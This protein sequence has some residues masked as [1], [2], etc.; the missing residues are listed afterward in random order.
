MLDGQNRLNASYLAPKMM[1]FIR[2][3]QGN[4][5]VDDATVQHLGEQMG[6]EF[7]VGYLIRK[8]FA[9]N[10]KAHW[11]KIQEYIFRLIERQIEQDRK[12][13]LL[14]TIRHIFPIYRPIVLFYCIM[15]LSEQKMIKKELFNQNSVQD[16]EIE[17]NKQWIDALCSLDLDDFPEAVKDLTTETGRLRGFLVGTALPRLLNNEYFE[18][19]EHIL[20]FTLSFVQEESSIVFWKEYFSLKRAYWNMLPQEPVSKDQR[21][22]VFYIALQKTLYDIFTEYQD[23][24]KYSERFRDLQSRLELQI[25]THGS[26]ASYIDTP[27][28]QILRQFRERSLLETEDN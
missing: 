19:S 25:R 7:Y 22:K 12:P 13:V 3:S 9:N 1:E 16:L 21:T 20:R 4:V 17:L 18:F 28:A 23:G 11:Q 14:H 10:Q 2:I 5:L 15:F 27:E 24:H 8:A 6:V 26:E